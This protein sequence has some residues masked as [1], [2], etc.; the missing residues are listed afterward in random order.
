[1]TDTLRVH[2]NELDFGDKQLMIWNGKPFTGVAVEFFPDGKLQSEEYYVDGIEHGPSR[3]WFPSGQL[4]EEM[5][6]WRGSLHGYYRMWDERGTLR[7]EA[8]CELGVWLAERR[9][10]EQGRLVRDWRLGPEDT[11]YN[12]LLLV[13]RKWGHLAP[14]IFNRPVP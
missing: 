7:E 10:D 2:V 6:H 9:W 4:L 13:R 3:V 8:L 1:M 11:E 5:N 14:P 12:T